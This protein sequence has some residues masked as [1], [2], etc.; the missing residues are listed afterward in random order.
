MNEK[1][2]F[3]TTSRTGKQGH[4]IKKKIHLPL[5]GEPAVIGYKKCKPSFWHLWSHSDLKALLTIYYGF[6]CHGFIMFKKKVGLWSEF[7][8]WVNKRHINITTKQFQRVEC[9]FICVDMQT[10][11]WCC[12][13][14]C[15][16]LNSVLCVCVH[17]SQSCKLFIQST[18]WKKVQFRNNFFF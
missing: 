9:T 11:S 4:Y 15:T 5:K 7:G 2:Y 1:C 16:F 10:A 13:A 3:K 18:H 12:S 8:V 14:I 17:L 6:L